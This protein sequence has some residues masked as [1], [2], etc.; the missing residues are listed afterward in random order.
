M[1]DEYENGL[2]STQTSHIYVTYQNK[3]KECWRV[4]PKSQCLCGHPFLDHT[5][6]KKMFHNKCQKCLCG[7]FKLVIKR[8]E[9]LNMGYLPR[10]KGFDITKWE[11]KC[12]C[13]HEVSKHKP[14][15]S[16]FEY[17][18][19][20]CKCMDFLSDYTCVGC[21]DLW[22][23]HEM[24]YEKEHDRMMKNKPIMEKYLPFYGDEKCLEWLK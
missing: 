15:I 8:P 22:N 6:D 7:D 21:D 16:K 17:K 9:G 12:K 11:P 1:K 13:G 24:V 19:K 3:G 10:R 2:W 5:L 14:S 18:C 20:D 23:N 4:G